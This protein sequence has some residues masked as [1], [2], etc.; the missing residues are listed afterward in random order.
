MTVERRN[1]L[2]PSAPQVQPAP[3]SAPISSAGGDQNS[4]T[5]AGNALTRPYSDARQ[6]YGSGAGSDGGGAGI[7]VGGVPDNFRTQGQPG[8]GGFGQVL[9]PRDP[10]TL[11]GENDPS[12][13]NG[14]GQ[15]IL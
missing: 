11:Q 12:T 9:G 14:G 4:G 8:D 2:G 6:Q 5:A 13:D 15:A 1:S 10:L 7:S 3:A